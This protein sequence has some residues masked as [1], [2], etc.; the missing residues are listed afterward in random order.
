MHSVLAHHPPGQVRQDRSHAL[1][2][3]GFEVDALAGS[4]IPDHRWPEVDRKMQ[5]A[6]R[7]LL[8]TRTASGMP[9]YL[10][11]GPRRSSLWKAFMTASSRSGGMLW[12]TAPSL[13]FGPVAF[14]VQSE[15]GGV[16]L[17][18]RGRYDSA[19]CRLLSRGYLACTITC[20]ST[21]PSNVQTQ[22][23][24]WII[25]TIAIRSY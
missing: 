23:L 1:K 8:Q 25:S 14:Q 18:F 10:I 24:A 22:A 17:E 6:R 5:Q 15:E 13:H 16:C 19:V 12:P 4:L 11:E 7:A 3:H 21:S 9:H 2:R 20:R